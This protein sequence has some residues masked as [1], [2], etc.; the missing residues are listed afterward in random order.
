MAQVNNPELVRNLSPYFVLRS[1]PPY[2]IYSAATVSNP[3]TATELSGIFGAASDSPVGWLG[4][5]DSGGTG[6]RV[7]LVTR[8]SGFWFYWQ[9]VKAT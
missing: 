6:T 5:V 3:P 1:D 2:P 4:L 8:R 9:A 7:Y